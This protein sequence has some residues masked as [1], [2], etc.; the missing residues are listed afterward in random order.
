[1]KVNFLTL[2]LIVYTALTEHMIS[3]ASFNIRISH[4]FAAIFVF[5]NLNKYI[6]KNFQFNSKIILS[7]FLIIFF[8]ILNDIII[9]VKLLNIFNSIF[10]YL[11]SL[12]LY[13]FFFNIF[14]KNENNLAKFFI[15]SFLSLLIYKEGFFLFFY[16]QESLAGKA[17]I[18][19]SRYASPFFYLTLGISYYF[20]L[21][22]KNSY[23]L[24]SNLL[25]LS[26][27]FY[28]WSFSHIFIITTTLILFYVLLIFNIRISYISFLFIIFVSIFLIDIFL[29][30]TFFNE[31][32]VFLFTKRADTFTFIP[33][34]LDNFPIG[35]GSK[36]II[37][38]YYENFLEVKK[39]LNSKGDDTYA[40]VSN[41]NY[42]T[43]HS[44]VMHMLLKHGFFAT[45]PF[46]YLFYNMASTIFK[47]LSHKKINRG[48]KY[49]STFIFAFFTYALM[50]NGI[51]SFLIEFPI[52]NGFVMSIKKKY[53]L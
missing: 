10:F 13:F 17:A 27:V 4:L 51:G 45:M 11:M 12:I 32:L 20:I 34:I 37:N 30:R 14:L 3:I 36:S 19:G 40:L 42:T 15:F 44:M 35:S 33:N 31:L 46:L 6:L 8:V 38:N 23:F 49:L 7:Y 22:K 47:I 29:L 43:T 18:F 24:L 26:L 50:F 39:Y 16:D 28:Y 2:I 25:F 52:Y 21:K 9:G 48:S 1:M 5:Y 41:E 53:T